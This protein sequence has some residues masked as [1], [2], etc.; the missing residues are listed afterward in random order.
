VAELGATIAR[1]RVAGASDGTILNALAELSGKLIG[2]IAQPEFESRL[3]ADFA[4]RVR[5]NIRR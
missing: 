5:G 3:A 1:L 2:V 4:R